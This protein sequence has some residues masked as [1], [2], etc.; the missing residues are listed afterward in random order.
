MNS[1][2]NVAAASKQFNRKINDYENMPLQIQ[3]L[4]KGKD[5]GNE[6]EKYKDLGKD[7]NRN[8]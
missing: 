7:R 3:I 2:E 4:D 5:K 1:F 6:N 8:I